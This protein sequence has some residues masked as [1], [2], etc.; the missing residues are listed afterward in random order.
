MVRSGRAAFSEGRKQYL[1]NGQ[2]GVETDRDGLYYMRARYYDQDIKRFIN[3][4]VLSGDIGNSQSLNRF[5]Y[6]QGN[7]V[8]LE[9]VSYKIFFVSISYG[10]PCSL[11]YRSAIF[12]ISPNFKQV[13]RNKYTK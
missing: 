10:S 4:D 12:N 11:I 3:R 9:F 8:S 6:V 2:Y 7:P 1:Y 13:I 5:C